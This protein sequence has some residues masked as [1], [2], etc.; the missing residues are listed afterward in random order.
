MGFSFY[1]IRKHDKSSQEPLWDAQKSFQLFCKINSQTYED[2]GKIL[3]VASK[4]GK[5]F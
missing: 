4:E 5:G 1:F 3:S 2:K